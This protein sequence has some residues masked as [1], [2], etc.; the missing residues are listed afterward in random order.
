MAKTKTSVPTDVEFI[1]VSNAVALSATGSSNADQFYAD[2]GADTYD[3]GSQ[4][5]GQFDQLNYGSAPTGFTAIRLSPNTVQISSAAFGVDTLIDIEAL[6]FSGDS[7]IAGKWYTVE[8]FMSIYGSD[9]YGADNSASP[10]SGADYSTVLSKSMDFYYAQY[11]GDLSQVANYPIS[12]RNS[13]HTNDGQDVG[14]NLSGGWYDAGDYVKFNLPMAYAATTLAWG[15]IDYKAGY[16]ASNSYDD[17]VQHLD[18]VSDY[19]FRCYDDKGTAS[20]AD[21]VF[22][23]QVG[24]GFLDH[25][26]VPNAPENTNVARPTYAI[27]SASGDHGSDVTGEAAAAMAS[28]SMVMRDAGM[29]AWADN[30]LA[31]AEKLFAFADEYEGTYNSAVENINSFYQSSGYEDE[32]AWAAVWLYEATSNPLYLA[33]AESLYQSRTTDP[34]GWDNKWIGVTAKL[35]EFTGDIQYMHDLEEHVLFFDNLTRVFGDATNDGLAWEGKWGSN[36]LSANMSFIAMQ[37]ADILEEQNA[38]ANA[39]KIDNIY[40]LVRDQIDFMLGDNADNQSYVVGFGSNSPQ[41]PHHRA[42]SGQTNWDDF[43]DDSI[44]NVHTLNGALVG[45]PS[46]D[47]ATQTY[48]YD[49][50]RTD[51]VSNEVAVDYNAAFSGVLAGLVMNIGANAAP[52][53][54]NDSGIQV[55]SGQS[56]VVSVLANDSDP[57]GAAL[58]VTAIN[59]IA[60]QAGWQTWVNGIGLVTLNANNT[61]TIAADAIYSGAFNLQYTVSDGQLTATATVSGTI[62][63]GIHGTSGNDT[64]NGTAAANTMYGYAGNDTLNGLGGNDNLQGGDGN[65]YLNGGAG[66]DVLNGGAGTDRANYSSATAGVTASLTTPSS[67]T[68]EAAGDS[69]VSI[70]NLFGS[71]LRDI[72]TGDAAV[73]TLWGNSGND[74]LYGLDGNDVLYGQAGVDKL[75]GGN[76]NDTLLGGA[77]NDTIDG[78]AGTDTASYG[79][80]TAAVTVNMTNMTVNTGDAAGDSFIGIENVTAGDFNDILVGNTG[81]NTLRGGA[82]NDSIYAEAGNDVVYGDAGADVLFGGA[83]NDSIEGGAGNDW[84]MGDAGNDTFIFR[85]AYGQDGIG[86][87]THGQDKLRFIG[88]S[89]TSFAQAQSIMV[90]TGAGTLFSFADGSTLTVH[91]QTPGS[92]TAADF[93]FA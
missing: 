87:F 83:G 70:E 81:V 26:A 82:G 52:V 27:T 24:D 8:Q 41:R 45:G 50:S 12:W 72:L 7:N 39:T 67:N 23:A 46:F 56:V 34:L 77:S 32:L 63:A 15:A 4:P 40:D 47:D 38:T 13:A 14:R 3:G 79:D 89:I 36:R 84:N 42:A 53:A 5:P 92:F 66:A 76:G 54:V 74:D 22:Y 1:T 30:L 29:V 75:Y 88:T 60:M 59:G 71:T 18:W 93:L 43:N 48:Y 21:D 28:V 64:L 16:V 44:A 6:W 9:G 49:D 2:A 33:K 68:G 37:Y 62:L 80:A 65:D 35:A 91:S 57:E 55:G 85:P 31:K 73:N 11:S 78:G 58:T 10:F 69:Y 19:L 61:L 86:D 90:A 25:Y 20:L 51:F 17:I